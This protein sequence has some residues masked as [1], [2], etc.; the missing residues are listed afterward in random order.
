MNK[1]FKKS[2]DE[3]I[4]ARNSTNNAVAKRSLLDIVALPVPNVGIHKRPKVTASLQDG[5]ANEGSRAPPTEAKDRELS[6]VEIPLKGPSKAP[7]E[8]ERLGVEIPVK[9][10]NPT[11]SD[12]RQ[13][14]SARLRRDQSHP[15]R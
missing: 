9:N 5:Q 8:E 4:N 3:M 1:S 14:K 11:V 10:F 6:G 12:A 15:I 2:R 13:R 7:R